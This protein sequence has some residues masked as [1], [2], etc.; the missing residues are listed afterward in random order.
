[1]GKRAVGIV[2]VAAV[3]ALIGGSVAA[4][5]AGLADDRFDD[6]TGPMKDFVVRPDA[7]GIDASRTLVDVPPL[8]DSVDQARAMDML[9]SLAFP[10]T[11]AGPESARQDARDL[12]TEQFVDA[13]Y[14]VQT[15][16]VDLNGVDS[17]NLYVELPGTECAE[18]TIVIGAHYD[19]AHATGAGADDNASGVGTLELARALE[20]HPLP[21]TVRFASW[22]YEEVGD[23]GSFAMAKQMEADQREVVGAISLEMIGF[24][25]PDTDPLTGLPS[26]YLGM[27]S[28]PTSAPL[29]KAFA[30]AAFTYTP[31][32]PAFGAVIDPNVLPDILRSDHA[33][34]LAS[35][36]PALM[37]TDTANFR[38]P[39]YH[40]ATD[41]VSTIDPDFL[42][43]STRA[44][45]A[46]LVTLGSVDQDQDGQADACSRD[47]NP[48]GATTTTAPSTTT[49]PAAPVAPHGADPVSGNADYTG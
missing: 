9:A 22:S 47:L 17:P 46:G 33:A 31:E 35:G 18:R 45:L 19:S 49:A 43:A 24:T 26:T 42:E 32:F 44:A 2:I 36:Y 25:K 15:Q 13:G 11:A 48:V 16:S 28:D 1:M 5:P 21:V 7:F 23:V 8:L 27:I 6:I 14:E 41:A 37:A 40:T 10:R 38:N 29:A 34:F 4:A 12:I 30:A 20:D 39:N 3:A